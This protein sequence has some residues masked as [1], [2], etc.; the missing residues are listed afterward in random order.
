MMRPPIDLKKPWLAA[1]LAWMVP[2]LGHFYQGRRA[3]AALYFTC[4][5]GLFVIGMGLGEGK[6]AF[7]RWVNPLHDSENFRL[8]Y[9]AQ[10]WVGLATFPALVQATLMRY[11]LNPILGGY[12]AEP[13]MN[14]INALHSSAGRYVDIG[15]VY[16][17][18]A[19]L[20]NILA[21]YDAYDGP[22]L[23]DEAEPAPVAEKVSLNLEPGT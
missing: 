13:P 2:G 4:I 9:P 16:T 8:W 21:I 15:V 11:G 20:L 19:G 7:W 14:V 5:M 12:L 23:A 3:K 6:I 22:A 18:I 17:C 10:F 1:L